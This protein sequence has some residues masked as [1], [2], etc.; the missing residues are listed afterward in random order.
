MEVASPLTFEQRTAGTK[1]HL[2]AFSP[3]AATGLA[4]LD[5]HHH[6]AV[7]SS[8]FHH[9]QRSFKRRRFNVDSSMDDVENITPQQSPFL[10]LASATPTKP[11]FASAFASASFNKRSR[12]EA[13]N[14]AGTNASSASAH[15]SANT[16]NNYTSSP[17]QQDLRPLLESQA[18]EI[19]TLK[20]EK[21]DLESSF[22]GLQTEHE[23]VVKENKLLRKAVN[24]QQDRQNQANNELHEA[25][26]FKGDAEV[27]IRKLEQM[28]M[29]LRYHLQTQQSHPGNDFMG[30][31]P[32]PPDVY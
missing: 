5:E 29:T 11:G 20:S 17:V 22:N 23:R 18:T 25:R 32:R 30:F 28:I 14:A 1:R 16:T 21:A 24:I 27:Q 10:A 4:P 12:S 15:A 3:A 31:P 26:K 2:S 7:V 13:Y 19:E 8:P 6:A 9:H